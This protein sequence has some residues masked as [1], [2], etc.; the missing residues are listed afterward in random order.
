MRSRP[1]VRISTMGSLTR[2]SPMVDLALSGFKLGK[3]QLLELLERMQTRLMF[4]P[5]LK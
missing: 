2:A 1:M 5:L 4:G 3:V